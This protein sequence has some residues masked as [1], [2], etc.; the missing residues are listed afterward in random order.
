LDEFKKQKLAKATVHVVG[1]YEARDKV[2]VVEVEDSGNPV[3]LVL[4]AYESVKWSVR[5][6]GKA[7]VV[8]II[9]SGYHRQ[10]VS[11]DGIPTTTSSYDEKSPTFF[12]THDHDEERY[13]NMVEKVRQLTGKKVASFEG[14]Y[15]FRETP[16]RVGKLE[17]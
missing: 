10:E 17:Y 7:E 4:C 1:L 9:A 5:P 8:Q 16:F 3:I 6:I 2:A 14:R 12:Y 15:S 11:A 13:P